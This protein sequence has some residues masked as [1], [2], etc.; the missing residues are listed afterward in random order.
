[1]TIAHALPDL[2]K[3]ASQYPVFRIA[4]GETNKFV[5]LVDPT[6]DGVDFVQVIEIFDVKGE[7]PPNA[8]RAAHETFVVLH[9]H[10][11][12]ITDAG[13]IPLQP[14]STLLVRPGGT[15]VVKNTGSSRLYCLT[16]MIPD[17]DFA[18]L[19]RGGVPDAL[20]EEDLAALAWKS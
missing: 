7:T 8:H 6:T 15:H 20:D 9:G 5:L 14:G 18:A 16:S 17:E 3:T 2:H 11:I 10:G 4:A 12:A 19:I 1:M 13:Q